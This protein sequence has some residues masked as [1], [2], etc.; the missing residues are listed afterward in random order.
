MPGQTAFL[1]L[2]T[3]SSFPHRAHPFTIVSSVCRLALPVHRQEGSNDHRQRTSKKTDSSTTN[4]APFSDECTFLIY[5]WEG[6]IRRLASIEKGEKGEKVKALVNGPYRFSPVLGSDSTVVPVAGGP[7]S[8]MLM[9]LTIFEVLSHVENKKSRSS[10]GP[11]SINQ[12]LH[13]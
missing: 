3:V 7:G 13:S 12:D 8:V 9:P 5:V 1:I 4:V 11:S 10:S 6:F 2:L